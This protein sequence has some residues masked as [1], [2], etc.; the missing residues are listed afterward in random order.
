MIR[1][2]V[3]NILAPFGEGIFEAEEGSI[4]YRIYVP[5]NAGENLPVLLFLHG[6]GERGSENHPQLI[7]ALAAFAK[8]NPEAKDS[9][10]IA[11]QCPAETQ[12]VNTP[13]YEINYSVD[14]VPESWQLKTVVKILDKVAAEYKAD[15]D[16]I[17]IMGISMGGFGT[18][19]MLMRHGDIFAAGMPI[20][21]GADP[22]KAELLRDIPIRTFHGDVDDAVLVQ[23]TRNIYNAIIEAGGKKIEYK[24]YKGEGHWVWDM[25]CS[26]EGIGAWLYSNKLSDRK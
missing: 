13:W 15:R 10:I 24:E 20:C 1:Y 19:D 11:P 23:G 4:P 12:W 14:E 22:S 17:Y 7:N 5:E 21:G 2:E 6:A 3:E 9:I 18:W 8:N 26:E 16:R 25:A